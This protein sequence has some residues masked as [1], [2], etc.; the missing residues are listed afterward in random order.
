MLTPDPSGLPPTTVATR[1]LVGAI[2]GG[3]YRLRRVLGRGGMGTVYKAENVAIGRTVA[4]KVL[5]HHLADEGVT[6]ARFQREARAAA[7]VGHENIVDVLD[8]GVEPSG[9]PYTVM[10][11]VRG[12]SLAQA[13]RDDG[14]FDPTRAA[15]IAGQ[16]LAALAAAH[17]E[18]IIHRDLKPENVMLTVQ[19]KKRDHVKLF[20]FGVA[21]IIDS[22]MDPSS[23]LTPSGK[24]MG[25]PAFAAPEQILGRRVRDARVDLYAVGVLLYQMLAGRVPFERPTFPE[26]CRAITDEPAPTFAQL[27]VEV[28]P[29]LEAVVHKALEKDPD[30]RFQYAEEMCEALVPFGA[31]P[32]V[33]LFESTDT[34]TM[35]L[36][37]LRA[38]E[39]ELEGRVAAPAHAAPPQVSGMALLEIAAFLEARFGAERAAALVDQHP[40]LSGALRGTLDP[41]AWYASP[42]PITLIEQIDRAEGRGDR[43]LVAEAGRFLAQRAAASA[44]DALGAHAPTPELL[45]SH[46]PEIWGRYL[47]VGEVTVA[48]L[49]RGY[50][51]LE[52]AGF[53]EPSLGLAA[54]V[55]GYLDEALRI[56]GARDVDVRV[57]RAAALGDDR[58]VLEATWSS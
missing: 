22:A 45:F 35:E 54:A 4:V 19:G 55:A 37:Q 33:E 11:Y 6:I 36:R 25:T 8:M 3:K 42:R 16:V 41:G 29:R 38:R 20:D 53:P 31:E 56:A 21:A 28:D 7:S 9:A 15:R 51:R 40:A 14:R 39:V 24:T 12:K 17:G 49:G 44:R 58:D 27:G 34:L 26:L 18:G 30:D 23:D 32:P 46:V 52:I 43:K 1:S 47:Q 10:E 57:A 50:G 5:H 13:L 48:K 2:I